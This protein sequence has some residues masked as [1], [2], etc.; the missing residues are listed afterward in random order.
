MSLGFAVAA[1]KIGV[2]ITKFLLKHYL[3][4]AAAAASSGLLDIAAGK[5]ADEESQRAAA[6][7]FEDIGDKI[8]KRL[9]PIFEDV[10]EG[11]A[12]SIAYEIGL[13]LE[14]RISAEFF[15]ERDLDPVILSAAFRSARP[16]PSGMFGSAETALYD[17]TLDESVRYIIG[18]AQSLPGFQVEVTA[19]ALGRLSRIGNDLEKTLEKINRIERLVDERDT[20]ETVKRY[21]TDYRQSVQRNLDYLELFGADISL[22]A[23]RHSLR[24]GYVSLYIVTEKPHQAAGE[25]Y[26]ADSLFEL[27]S[28][29]GG[30]LLLRGHAG[31]GKSTLL[32]WLAIQAAL[33]RSLTWRALEGTLR[34]VYLS[35]HVHMD[36]GID[37]F[38]KTNT[39]NILLA[40]TKSDFEMHI[41]SNQFVDVK[42]IK[43]AS[44]KN[45]LMVYFSGHGSATVE[46][47]PFLIR[48]RDCTGARLPEPDNLPALIANELGRPPI[49][50]VRSTLAEGKGLLLLDGV[51]EVPNQRRETMRRDLEALI[52]RYPKN[53]F[54]VTTRPEAVPENWLRGAGFIEASLNPMSENDRREFIRC[55]HSAVSDELAR[56]GRAE[57]LSGLAEELIAKLSESPA[58]SR[59]ATNP[60]LC[61]AM[62]ALHRDRHRRLPQSQSELCEALC[63]L[64]LHRRETE[65]GPHL[66]EFPREYRDLTYEQKRAVVQE[67]AHYMV[68]NDESVISTKD[69]LVITSNSLQR[70]P[71]GRPDDAPVVLRSLIE[72]SGVLRE[73]KAGS[74][75]FLHNTI[76]EF[77]SA[78]MFVVA[79][80]YALLGRRS[81]DDSWRPVVLFASASRDREFATELVK[82]ILQLADESKDALLARRLKLAA[83]SCRYAALHMEASVVDHLAAIERDLVPPRN[84]V[85][86]EALAGSG[87]NVVPL[88]RHRRMPAREAAACVRTLRLI[89]TEAAKQVLEGYIGDTRQAVVAELGQA[90]NPLRLAALRDSMLQG[91][92]ISPR[93]SR[94]ITDLAPLTDV[95]N[96]ERL[97]LRGAPISECGAL[98]RMPSLKWLD[99]SG[100]G[101]ICL[102][103]LSKLEALETLDLSDTK[104]ADLSPLNNLI[105]L[106]DLVCDHTRVRDLSPLSQLRQLQ[107]LNVRASQVSDFRPLEPLSALYE[108]IIAE[109]TNID[110][111]SLRKMTQLNSINAYRASGVDMS[112][113]QALPNLR[114]LVLNATDITDVIGLTSCRSL[115]R[116][117]ISFTRVRDIQPLTNLRQLTELALINLQ[118]T[119]FSC[120]QD[121]TNLRHLLLAHTWFTDLRLLKNCADLEELDLDN[122]LVRDLQPI[123]ALTEL[124]WLS[125]QELSITD[126]RPL[127][128]LP[129][130]E[131]VYLSD[132]TKGAMEALSEISTLS[133]LVIQN[134]VRPDFRKALRARG[135]EVV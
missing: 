86:A 36:H 130:L 43:Q 124:K 50:W 20:N 90:V 113:L 106:Q 123:V 72:R 29:K 39:K 41:T 2:P 11:T 19:A 75:D 56:Q 62:C 6:R 10:D 44:L 115:E 121:L 92:P 84:M 8:V 89:G 70:F 74:I 95:E 96:I 112:V 122:T 110:W 24:V 7:L 66:S 45:H 53:Q 63:H 59:L 33:K 1:A 125:L 100:T 87:D 129:R 32:R 103:S 135:V 9:I 47:I 77:L 80:D 69:T 48:L 34:H 102:A 79:R 127:T 18:I 88:L 13:T 60:L 133:L 107:K 93:L 15:V 26:S 71:N 134:P 37:A 61:A 111:N 98:E 57:D 64:L 101:I 117:W 118:I 55:W 42:T 40:I 67:I 76:K 3:G 27:L 58:I 85:D 104:I 131:T 30:R 5:I 14:G 16:L 97:T 28:I 126:W 99:L 78:E 23:Q 91:E 94:Q 119:D 52:G 105:K 83:V 49:D 4:E 35:S 120:F 128:K 38:L 31:S 51:D 21:E 108:L 68:R 114:S 109:L 46:R 25:T 82:R 54:I 116:L 81:V 73:K 17:R 12:E 22:E 65:S 132:L